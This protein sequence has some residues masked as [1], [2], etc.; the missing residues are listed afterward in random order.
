MD[1]LKGAIK[2][3]YKDLEMLCETVEHEIADAND[4]IQ[5]S[6]GK[7]TAGDLEMLDKLTHMMKSIKTTMAMMDSE[8]NYGGDY[9]SHRGS[10][11]RDSMGRYTRS[12]GMVRELRSMMYRAPEYLKGDIERVISKAERM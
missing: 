5:A 3:V 10:Y 8:S 2:D 11:R 7:I 9:N 12:D 1:C 6:G 4:K